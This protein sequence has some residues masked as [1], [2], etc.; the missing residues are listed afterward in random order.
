[1]S[2]IRSTAPPRK[3]SFGEL[4]VPL[5][6]EY[7]PLPEFG[8]RYEIRGELGRGGMGVVYLAHDLRGGREVALKSVR[9]KVATEEFMV[10][11]RREALI[12]AQLDHP[13]VLPVHDI[14][15]TASGEPFF[16]MP[17][18]EG[19][20]LAS[21][22]TRLAAG[23]EET[24][25]AWG[26]SKVLQLFVRVCGT[27]AHA[28]SRGIAH[29][30][31][32]PANLLVGRYADAYVLDWG[33]AKLVDIQD[34][35][36]PFATATGSKTARQYGSPGYMAPEQV[37]NCGEL[38]DRWTD[39][40]S[41]GAILFEILT[42]QRLHAG[43]APDELLDSTLR[44][45]E[46]RPTERAP[47]RLIFPEW[48]RVCAKAT[49]KNPSERFADAAALLAACEEIISE[50][51]EAER[52]RQL[53]TKE[54]D[55][56]DAALSKREGVGALLPYDQEAK[57][58]RHLGR[59]LALDPTNPEALDK[60]RTMVLSEGGANS[61][62][63]ERS[64]DAARQ[65]ERIAAMRRSRFVVPGAALAIALAAI[66][67][68]AE[69]V[70]L[71]PV[72]ALGAAASA[73]IHFAVVKKLASAAHYCLQTFLVSACA[74]CLSFVGGVLF[75]PLGLLAATIII[76]VVNSRL[77]KK[78]R[79]SLLATTLGTI[80]AAVALQHAGG[81][82]VTYAFQDGNLLIDSSAIYFDSWWDFMSLYVAGFVA[83]VAPPLMVGR[84][85]DALNRV[86]RQLLLRVYRLANLL[87]EQ[88]EAGLPSS[89]RAEVDKTV[90]PREPGP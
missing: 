44:G 45:A 42:L 35:G 81:F 50:L 43:E 23:D 90:K 10:R 28:H 15:E 75:V 54:H 64:L 88:D 19:D 46:A 72:V 77:G 1:M 83:I 13:G 11:F 86:E 66:P 55:A 68:I 58:I 48:N 53:A 38:I 62:D 78:G 34:E 89:G 49:S 47:D 18:V 3:Q 82:G 9:R 41:L 25:Q 36:D 22:L 2:V 33:L 69:P 84:T 60:L 57:A 80:V 51:D 76:V 79:W 26:Q 61:P 87:P 70:W 8:K 16:T 74:L 67:A 24:Q 7:G 14:Q 4:K 12:Q 65:I 20:T 39:V 63:F 30:D 29:R 27:V 21:V 6:T 5:E 32:K 17:R 56:A 59:A 85:I 52:R 73:Y 71:I 37:M 31:L 40:Y